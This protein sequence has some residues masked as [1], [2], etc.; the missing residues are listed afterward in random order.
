MQTVRADTITISI[1]GKIGKDRR[2]KIVHVYFR[3]DEQI[4][5]VDNVI[6]VAAYK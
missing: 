1:T 5:V 6:M 4:S 2:R 3:R